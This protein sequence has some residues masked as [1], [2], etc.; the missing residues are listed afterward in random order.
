MHNLQPIPERD[1]AELV[2]DD[3]QDVLAQA[4]LELDRALTDDMLARIEFEDSGWI[5]VLSTKPVELGGI[6]GIGLEKELDAEGHPIELDGG[7][8][9]TSLTL[10]RPLEFDPRLHP[11][12]HDAK[13]I[14]VVRFTD[15]SETAYVFTDEW[16]GVANTESGQLL[17]TD[18]ADNTPL[19]SKLYKAMVEGRNQSYV[20]GPDELS[21]EPDDGPDEEQAA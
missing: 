3:R 17:T 4:D 10:I 16:H 6:K 13:L 2:V 18:P 15:R 12:V 5:P 20:P 7:K 19:F 14:T 9:I 11:V 1:H 21:L 8:Q